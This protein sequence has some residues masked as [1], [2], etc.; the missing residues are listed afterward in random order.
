MIY[1]SNIRKILEDK[2]EILLV[3]LRFEHLFDVCIGMCECIISICTCEC[4]H[5]LI[6]AICWIPAMINRIV[7]SFNHNEVIY[8]LFLIQVIFRALQG[9]CNAL[10]FGVNSQLMTAITDQFSRRA[11]SSMTIDTDESP[12][13]ESLVTFTPLDPHE[14]SKISLFHENF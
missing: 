2:D 8:Q 4:R 6:I 7:E 11:P 10:V 1:I 9:T 13:L 14:S 3:E 12:F 5:P